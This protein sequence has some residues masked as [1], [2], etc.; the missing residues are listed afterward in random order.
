VRE[1]ILSEIRR[2]ATANNGVPPGSRLFERETGIRAKEWLGVYWP[3]WSEALVEAGFEPNQKTEKRADEI[4]LRQFAGVVRH[5]GKLPPNMEYR[6][7]RRTNPD[8]PT[9]TTITRAFGSRVN[10]INQLAKWASAR[11]E[12]QDV[13]QILG[14]QV[15]VPEPNLRDSKTEGLVYLIRAGHIIKSAAAMSLSAVSRKSKWHFQKRHSL[16][17]QFGQMIRPASKRIGTGASPKIVPMANGSRSQPPML[18]LSNGA[19]SS[20]SPDDQPRPNKWE[21]CS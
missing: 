16:C 14:A 12:F 10:L 19:S 2:M 21:L 20:N 9:D 5:F 13:A 1:Q 15:V 3:R 4:L 8:L 11:A 18:R 6:M 17:V 7:H